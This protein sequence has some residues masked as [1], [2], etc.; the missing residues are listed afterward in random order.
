LAK[1]SFIPRIRRPCILQSTG[2]GGCEQRCR[3]QELAFS[4]WLRKT[5]NAIGKEDEAP[6]EPSILAGNTSKVAGAVETGAVGGGGEGGHS[7]VAP[8]CGPGG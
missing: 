5:K 2:L 4:S 7:S 6:K 8:A 1:D 3:D